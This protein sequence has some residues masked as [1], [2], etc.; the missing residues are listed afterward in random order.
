MGGRATE[1]A[2]QGTYRDDRADKDEVPQ[3]VLPSG[4][5][6][7]AHLELARVDVDYG[8]RSARK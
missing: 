7:V 6:R 4:K 2:E 5:L 1:L 8:Q 3:K